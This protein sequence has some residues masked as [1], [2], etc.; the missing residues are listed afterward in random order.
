MD[1]L[2]VPWEIKLER[3]ALTSTCPYVFVNIQKLLTC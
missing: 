2:L 3:D 1:Y